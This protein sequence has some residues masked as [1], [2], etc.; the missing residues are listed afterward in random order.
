MRDYY[1][2]VYTQRYV[3]NMTEYAADL[4]TSAGT[5]LYRQENGVLAIPR[6]QALLSLVL[7]GAGSMIIVSSFDARQSSLSFPHAVALALLATLFILQFVL[8]S[9]HSLLGYLAALVG[10][11]TIF[12]LADLGFSSEWLYG[13]GLLQLALLVSDMNEMARAALKLMLVAQGL[14]AIVLLFVGEPAV[15]L[16]LVTPALFTVVRLVIA[17]ASLE[18]L[19]VS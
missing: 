12:T 8:A 2:D 9:E 16:V 15:A 1:A 5:P 10:P 4:Y 17:N 13:F 18:R 19:R 14:L 3:D 7:G 6:W 11:A